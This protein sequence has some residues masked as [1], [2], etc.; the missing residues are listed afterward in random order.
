[1]HLGHI[2]K[3]HQM[4]VICNMIWESVLY[5]KS[6][7]PTFS[8]NPQQSSVYIPFPFA[9]KTSY[10]LTNFNT[11]LNEALTQRG[12]TILKSKSIL[13]DFFN[14]LIMPVK[15]LCNL[16]EILLETEKI[17]QQVQ[18]GTVLSHQCSPVSA[19]GMNLAHIIGIKPW[20]P[21][22]ISQN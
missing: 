3:V 8:Q 9:S 18:C 5:H 22:N 1:M 20:A 6:P 15:V 12:L 10:Y 11:C 2:L 7:Q 16:K 4:T 13:Y 17:V 14:K 21:I 19:L